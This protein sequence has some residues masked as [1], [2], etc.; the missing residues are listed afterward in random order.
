[1][2]KHYALF[3]ILILAFFGTTLWAEPE[4]D[5]PI[6]VA[7]FDLESNNKNLK[8]MGMLIRNLVEVHL[9]GNPNMRLV[10]R[11]EI[12]KIIEENKLSISGLTDDAMPQLGHLL[13]AQVLIVGRLFTVSDKLYITARI[14]GTDTSRTYGSAVSGG[15]SE[16]E[17]MSEELAS[18]LAKLIEEKKDTLV[19]KVKLDKDQIKELKKKIG[20][21]NLPNVY[22]CVHEQVVGPPVIDPAA[23]TEIEHILIKLGFKVYKDKSGLL[24]KWAEKYVADGGKEAPPKVESVDL[25]FL[26]EGISEFAA[27]NQDLVSYRSRLE[28]EVISPETGEVINV[29]RDTFVAV[30]LSENIAAKSS[31]QESAARLI[32]K[33]LPETIEK[34]KKLN[35]E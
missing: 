3:V 29:D 32:Q 31:L 4:T 21:K 30:D 2:K 16:I 18:K 23:Q 12:D 8:D 14:V 9:T 27:R 10:T 7:V 25:I 35:K 19:V 22:V 33:I 11:T 6:T 1:M 5:E 15:E 13:G 34:W 17:S 26:G 20:S 24:K 28:L